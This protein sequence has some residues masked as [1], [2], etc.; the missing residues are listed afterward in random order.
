M[1][2][3]A[4]YDDFENADD[5]RNTDNIHLRAHGGWTVS[6]L[7]IG[8][9]VLKLRE[10]GVILQG[11]RSVSVEPDAA[12]V[13][14]YTRV[15][16]DITEAATNDYKLEWTFQFTAAGFLQAS[17]IGTRIEGQNQGGSA[18]W[19][20]E[21]FRDQII[22]TDTGGP[23]ASVFNPGI[24]K[25][26]YTM[27]STAAGA[28]DFLVDDVSQFAGTAI[29]VSPTDV[30]RVALILDPEA[31]QPLTGTLDI[32]SFQYEVATTFNMGKLFVGS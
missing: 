8:S 10:S 19:I 15:F 7:G 27:T 22:V 20:V 14:T 5:Y 24:T 16:T 6:P 31:T 26:K 21:M 18:P 9:A 1:L 29:V 13:A 25:H 4:F 32:I 28:L 17:G 3:S 2:R 30:D 23:S 12:G 11:I